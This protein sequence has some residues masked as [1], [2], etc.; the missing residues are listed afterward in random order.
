MR[1]RFWGTRGS[2]AK[3]GPATVRYGGNTSC[4][5]VRAG[6]GTL[7][8]LD[9]GTGAHGL[10]Q[11]LMAAGAPVRGHLLITHTH[12]DHIQG[13]PFFG[14]LFVPGNDWDVYAPTGLGRRL[15][16]TLAGQMEYA[17]FPMTLDQLG[18]T[19]RYHDVVEGEFG[20]GGVRV[21]AR[22]LN[23]PALA[24]GY[25]LEA[26]GVSIVYATDH[27]PH[28]PPAGVGAISPAPRAAEPPAHREDQRHREF[29]AGADLVIHDAQYTQAEYAN[30]LGWGHSPAEYAVDAALAAGARRLALFHHDPQRDDDGVDHLVA[31]SRARV[32]AAA[33]ALDVLGAAEG[34][35][36]ELTPRQ[37]P[38]AGPSTPAAAAPAVVTEPGLESTAERQAKVLI[39]DDDVG[40]V[41]TLTMALWTEG[42][43]VLSAS[44]GEAGLAMAGAERPD[45]VLLDSGLPK[46]DGLAICR[47]LRADPDPHIREMPVVLLTEYAGHDDTAAGFAAG[48]T[49][50]V[51]KPFSPAHIRSRVH[52]WLLRRQRGATP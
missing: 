24:L 20:V 36:I 45:L 15:E 33:G 35:L 37:S 34:L 47:A 17:Y 39:I 9:C 14:P 3:P 50:Y 22:Y 43:Q 4:V 38:T 28:A 48:A 52:A 1:V 12:W 21:V 25:R 26:A 11:S 31:A 2:I 46:R 8:V 27:E 44:D 41:H 42:F 19:I 13:F 29:L 5:E 18:A 49:D 30:K 7:I 32:A 6:D 10:G 51:T 16:D 23:H 40:V